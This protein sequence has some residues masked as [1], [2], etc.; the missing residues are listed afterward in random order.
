MHTRKPCVALS[1]KRPPASVKTA[2][3]HH[4]HVAACQNVNMTT[5]ELALQST[6]ALARQLQK[7]TPEAYV[8]LLLSSSCLHVR[9]SCGKNNR[10]QCQAVP[11]SPVRMSSS[12]PPVIIFSFPFP[13]PFVLCCPAIYIAFPGKGGSCGHPPPRHPFLPTKLLGVYAGIL[14]RKCG[15]LCCRV[16]ISSN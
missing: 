12:S 3:A 16:V 4:G 11:T 15:H 2:A 14:N 6:E 10:P 13:H 8:H 9:F 7:A 5:C 1:G